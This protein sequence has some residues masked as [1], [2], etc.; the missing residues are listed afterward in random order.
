ML[1]DPIWANLAG[2]VGK[3]RKWVPIDK[4]FGIGRC[5][6]PVMYM[7]HTD[8]KN[9]GSNITD[10]MIG[11]ANWAPNWDPGIQSWLIPADDPISSRTSLSA[12]ML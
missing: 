8:V 3:S 1:E 5:S 10:L 11:S 2:G 9:D 7:S 12:W 4:N 6:G